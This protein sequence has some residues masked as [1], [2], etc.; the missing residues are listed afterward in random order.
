MAPSQCSTELINIDSL[1]TSHISDAV[2]PGIKLF[3]EKLKNLK[4]FVVEFL[5][6]PS[7]LIVEF[8][9]VFNSTV[10]TDISNINLASNYAV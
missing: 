2:I 4:V 3:L 5:S 9:S 10:N 1:L 7:Q 8:L 6:Q